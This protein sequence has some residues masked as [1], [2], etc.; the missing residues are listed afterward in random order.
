MTNNTAT[1]IYH[2]GKSIDKKLG[3]LDTQIYGPIQPTPKPEYKT[4]FGD[5]ALGFLA[6]VFLITV[7][8]VRLNRF[9]RV[10]QSIYRK[11]FE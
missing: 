7:I 2:L 10:K 3:T 6:I 11:L 4:T 1:L 9:D 8:V 5:V